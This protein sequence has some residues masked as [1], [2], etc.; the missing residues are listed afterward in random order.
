MNYLFATCISLFL[1]SFSVADHPGHDNIKF[2]SNNITECTLA[3]INV[4][5]VKARNEKDGCAKDVA[6]GKADL[7]LASA[8]EMVIYAKELKIVYGQKLKTLDKFVQ[9]YG[10]AIV[11]KG[12]NF[13]LNTLKGKNTCHTTVGKTVGWNIPVGYLLF[14]KK[15]TFTKNE[16]RSASDYFGD[17][18]APGINDKDVT[19]AVKKDLCKLCNGTC[20]VNST[21]PYYDYQ[22]AFKC[23]ADGIKDRVGF[24]KQT[25]A[26]EVFAAAG[27]NYGDASD[28]QLL[29]TD[30]TKADLSAYRTCNIDKRPAYALVTNKDTPDEKVTKMKD[31]L[32]KA[33]LANL[34]KGSIVSSNCQNLEAY[35][36]TV[37]KYVGAYGDHYNALRSHEDISAASSNLVSFALQIIAIFAFVILV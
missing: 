30:G 33:V 11:K 14:T 18:C 13:T 1:V 8:N 3:G 24:V 36:D 19:D 21:E 34:K 6:D 15:M 26:D 9:Y 17:S 23:M 29:C 2:C 35:T 32:D 20:A 5:C 28:Y 22:G 4:T 16:Y 25:T 31:I 37:K 27:G 7:M 12:T 10:L